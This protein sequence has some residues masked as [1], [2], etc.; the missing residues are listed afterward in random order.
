MKVRPLAGLVILVVANNSLLILLYPVGPVGW[1]P[2]VSNATKSSTCSEGGLE[3]FGGRDRKRSGLC[4]IF[5]EN[6]RPRT[7]VTVN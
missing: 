6:P 3:V 2:H 7:G 1:A 5:L 4:G